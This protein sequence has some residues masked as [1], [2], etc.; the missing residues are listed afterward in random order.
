MKAFA[1]MDKDKSGTIDLNDIRG[2]YTA[3]SHPDVKS[4]KKTEDEVLYE[5]LDT[6]EQHHAT[7]NSDECKD[8]RDGSVT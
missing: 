5:F 4:G 3:K 6:F 8:A 7:A 1:I 2:V